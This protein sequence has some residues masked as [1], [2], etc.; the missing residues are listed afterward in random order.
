MK[1]EDE[2]NEEK[3]QPRLMS[4]IYSALLFSSSMIIGAVIYAVGVIF[5]CSYK[6]FGIC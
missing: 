1:I 2:L 3:L 5:F 6:C 4:S